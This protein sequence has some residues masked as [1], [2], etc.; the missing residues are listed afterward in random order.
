MTIRTSTLYKSTCF[1]YPDCV[2]KC[3]LPID[4]FLH[5]LHNIQAPQLTSFT[6]LID[7]DGICLRCYTK[8]RTTS[9]AVMCK[10]VPYRAG[11][12]II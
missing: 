1:A 4:V 6:K 9:R 2:L 10:A 11:T 7:I 12:L 5:R 8:V 3:L